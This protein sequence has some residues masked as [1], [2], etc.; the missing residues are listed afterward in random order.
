MVRPTNCYR[1]VFPDGLELR[2]VLDDEG[3]GKS[4]LAIVI[5]APLEGTNC[6]AECR[7]TFP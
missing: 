2:E 7:G 1:I 5:T 6:I 4:W 3:E